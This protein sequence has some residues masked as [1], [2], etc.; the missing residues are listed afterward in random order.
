MALSSAS[1]ALDIPSDSLGTAGVDDLLLFVGGDVESLPL[2]TGE[3]LD[4]LAG[5]IITCQPGEWLVVLFAIEVS[6]ELTP[7][8]VD[9]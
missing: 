5:S 7:E 6:G 4:L 3:S 1:S 2:F 9:V 8:S